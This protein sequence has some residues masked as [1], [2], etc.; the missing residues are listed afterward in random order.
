MGL[1]FE[2][3]DAETRALMVDEINS[4][5]AGQGIYLSSWFNPQG[6]NS[7]PRLLL[8][9]AA[10]GT[11]D[12]LANEARNSRMFLAQYSKRKPKGGMTLADVPRTAHQTLSESQFNMYY[13][14]ALALR[15][16][17]NGLVLQVYRARA[18]QN[19]RPGSEEMVDTIIDPN[20]VLDVLRRTKGVE[21]TIG[22]PMPNSGLSVRLV[23]H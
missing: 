22:I 16:I 9:A 17:R 23:P 12:S 2:H 3:L 13:I 1:H 20:V 7:W 11:D 14:R 8:A 4:D 6:A 5:L 19:P 10:G 18:S 15:A 21:P